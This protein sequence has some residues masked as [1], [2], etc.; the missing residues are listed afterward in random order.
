MC[1]SLSVCKITHIKLRVNFHGKFQEMLIMEQDT[2]EDLEDPLD[3]R[4]L[5]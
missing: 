1:I 4:I 3:S 5:F 2:D